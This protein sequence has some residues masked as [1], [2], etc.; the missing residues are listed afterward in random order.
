MKIVAVR[1]C[2]S[3]FIVFSRLLVSIYLHLNIYS[4]INNFREFN[5]EIVTVFYPPKKILVNSLPDMHFKKKEILRFSV[6][7]FVI[8]MAKFSSSSS[9][10]ITKSHNETRN[11]HLRISATMVS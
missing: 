11:K 8:A 3:C 6:Q 9:T 5:Y 4:K 2:M 7:L 10:G 1:S